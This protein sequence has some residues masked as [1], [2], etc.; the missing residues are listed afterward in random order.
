MDPKTVYKKNKHGKTQQWTVQVSSIQQ[1][2]AR[3]TITYGQ[4]NG[5]LQTT[6]R[7]ITEGKN[8][9]KKSETTP[10]QQ[11]I[12]EAQ[13]LLRQKM[14]QHGY[15][16]SEN[17]DDDE[18]ND[19][20]ILPMLAENYK[21]RGS[22][23]TF[24][25]FAQPK[26]D[27]VRCLAHRDSNGTIQLMSRM[28]KPFFF[29]D[30]IRR[31]VSDLALDNTVYLD[32]ELFTQQGTFQDITSIC[33]QTKTPHSHESAILFHVFDFFDKARPHL[34]FAE[35]LCLLEK[36]TFQT[37]IQLVLTEPLNAADDI[38]QTLSV[39]VAQ[40]YEGIILRNAAGIYACNQRSAC[41]QKYKEFQDAE[42]RIVG[43]EE[44][45]GRASGMIIYVCEYTTK[46]DTKDV[47]RVCRRGTHKE[48]TQWFQEGPDH[49]GKMLTVRFQK[50]SDNGAPIFPVGVGIRDYE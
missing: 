9:N 20:P 25:C 45:K 17:D 49:I 28:G 19:I 22:H 36:M 27:G 48:R 37:P 46:Q 23:I 2:S 41:L 33:K 11:A 47:F 14:E 30:H 32:G 5:V 43:F 6:A 39:Y 34:T 29:L 21:H 42:F 1:G 12:L 4:S 18:T 10:I 8:K 38:S 50:Y 3:I 16:E 26:L 31:G 7:D 40:Q 15:R 44:S 24:P 35:R 13:S